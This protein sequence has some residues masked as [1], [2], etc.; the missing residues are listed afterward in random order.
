ML[1]LVKRV[2]CDTNVTVRHYFTSS[3]T[4]SYFMVTQIWFEQETDNAVAYK[5]CKQRG[6]LQIGPGVS[7]RII[8][9]TFSWHLVRGIVE[10]PEERRKETEIRAS[11]RQERQEDSTERTETKPAFSFDILTNTAE[12]SHF[13]VLLVLLYIRIKNVKLQTG[14]QIDLL[15]CSVPTASVMIQLYFCCLVTICSVLLPTIHHRL[16]SY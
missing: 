7:W 9:V 16:M 10:K 14:T 6:E 12:S 1:L 4:Q 15:W 13:L 11:E 2:F 8:N 5:E 3:H